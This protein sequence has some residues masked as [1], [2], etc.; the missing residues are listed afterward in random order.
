MLGHRAEE[1]GQMVHGPSA[2]KVCELQRGVCCCEMQK[3][4]CCCEM[5]RGGLLWAV[6]LQVAEGCAN[7]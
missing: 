1:K 4:V 2:T 7:G 6:L 3:G 5:Q